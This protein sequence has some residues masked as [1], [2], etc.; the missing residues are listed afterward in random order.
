MKKKSLYDR[1]VELGCEID[2]HG[3]DLYVRRTPEAYQLIR[4]FE[5]EGGITNK[6]YFHS[7]IDASTWID[8]PFL[9]DPYWES[10]RRAADESDGD[11]PSPRM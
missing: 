11:A 10:K 5:A 8:L 7:T 3:A 9:Y 1:V 4:D 6:T 2:H